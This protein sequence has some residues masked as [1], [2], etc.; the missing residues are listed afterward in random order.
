[1]KVKKLDSE[2]LLN[3]SV[4]KYLI[5][6]DKVVSKPQKRFKDF[7]RPYWFAQCVCEEVRIPSTLFRLDIVN[8]T[9]RE[10]VEVSPSQHVDPTH[11]FNQGDK[12][13]FAKSLKRDMAKQRW[14]EQNNFKYYELLDEDL[15]NLNKKYLYE[16][17]DFVI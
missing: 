1:M 16:K 13:A 15:E 4:T 5:D 14:A 17:F 8:F 11:F 3:L 10:I 9:T 2:K 6:W 12:F 7:I